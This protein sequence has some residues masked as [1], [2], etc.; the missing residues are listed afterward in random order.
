MLGVTALVDLLNLL[1][2]LIPQTSHRI[3]R[4]IKYGIISVNRCIT[5]ICA[6][7]KVIDIYQEEQVLK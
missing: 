1:V 7:G 6:M 4:A 5:I 3:G 2:E